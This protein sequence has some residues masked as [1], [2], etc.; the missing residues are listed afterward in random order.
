MYVSTQGWRKTHYF[1]K[2]KSLILL[3]MCLHTTICVSSC[4]YICVCILLYVCPHTTIYSS[5]HYLYALQGGDPDKL[6][7]YADDEEDGPGGMA[8][9]IAGPQFTS[10]TSIKVQI[11]T[12]EELQRKGRRS[13]CAIRL[14]VQKYVLTGTKVQN[15]DANTV[16]DLT[17]SALQMAAI[18]G[19][20]SLGV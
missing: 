16:A 7:C 3:Y 9:M 15:T 1:W 6:C 14:Q 12:P 10:F 18:A 8:R 13:G 19:H 5:S 20:D 11:L 17:P 4:Y 2:F